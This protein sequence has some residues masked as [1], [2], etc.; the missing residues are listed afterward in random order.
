MVMSNGIHE[1]W[2]DAQGLCDRAEKWH[3]RKGCQTP[4]V[5]VLPR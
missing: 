3:N 2:L 1:M 4:R 5:E